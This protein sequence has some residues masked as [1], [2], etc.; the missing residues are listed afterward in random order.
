[1]SSNPQALV[2]PNLGLHLARRILGLM[3][4]FFCFYLAGHYLLGLSFPTPG[5][6]LQIGTAILLGSLL[7]LTFSRVWPLPAKVG[8]ERV[9]RTVLL[10]IPAIGFGL[11]LQVALQ[12][13][14][15][16]QAIYLVFAASAWLT[17]SLIVRQPEK[18]QN[19]QGKS[20]K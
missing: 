8:L 9:I 19:Y 2:P 10:L 18:G 16:T 17:S 12:G 11:G 5:V 6:L 7:G 1:M 4:F 13:P 14:N 15:P 20:G 3:A